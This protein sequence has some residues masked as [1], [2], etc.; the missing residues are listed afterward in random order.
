MLGRLRALE[1]GF[2]KASTSLPDGDADP[3]VRAKLAALGYV[4]SFVA[5]A[6]DPRT[7]RADPKDK[8]R[9]FNKLGSARDLS[10]ERQEDEA[11]P[12]DKIIALLNEVVGEDPNVIDAWFMLG[13]QYF[14]QGNFTKAVE[15]YKRT[16]SLKP[17]YDI[18]VI[19]L[20]AAYRG[21]G[22]DEAALAGFEHYLKID[23]KD[24]WV[25]YRI[26]EIWLDR[27]DLQRAEEQFQAALSV[28]DKVAPAKNALGVI[29]FK[30]GDLDGAERLA[31]EA[32]A[33]RSDVRLAHYNLALI[34]EQRGDIRAA[35][36][37]YVE[38]LKA[39]PEAYKA[40]YNL[41]RL[42]EDVGDREGQ[43]GA[44]KQ[45][46]EGNPRFVEGHMFLAKAYLDS[47]QK[48]DE[49]LRLA[50]KGL[51][52][53]PTAEFAALGHYVLADIYS[54][55]G[56]PQESA[57]QGALGRASEARGRAGGE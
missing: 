41:S 16:L 54:R 56:K 42:Y 38:E 29:A 53:G 17:D 44:L 5:S 13:N 34:A 55:Q 22:D 14:N 43:I 23:P 11:E 21:L 48:L 8:I 46:I 31:R 18:A 39:H 9:L 25:R 32:L 40:A 24:A 27:G 15:Y 1:A 6:A 10:K 30:R 19:N 28:D 2:E 49:A 51:E 7:G 35:E 45:A 12:V 47:G 3:E 26:G 50:Q 4:G 52:L 36:R 20:A 37:E 33:L 57:R